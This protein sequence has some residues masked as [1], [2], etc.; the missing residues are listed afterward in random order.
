[1]DRNMSYGEE[2]CVA[3]M[4]SKRRKGGLTDVFH[5]SDLILVSVTDSLVAYTLLE[6]LVS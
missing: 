1:M 4:T 2:A 3:E 5:K 6:R